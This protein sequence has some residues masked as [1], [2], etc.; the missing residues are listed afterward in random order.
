MATNEF[1]ERV[2]ELG[3]RERLS[4]LRTLDEFFART[5]VN[6]TVDRELSDLRQA[7]R[8]GGRRNDRRR[9]S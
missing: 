6:C 3:E 8:A 4:M 1:N 9:D 2:G 7:R 5:P